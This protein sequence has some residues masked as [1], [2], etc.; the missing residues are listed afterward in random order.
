MTRIARAQA[1]E[2]LWA[3]WPLRVT[4]ALVSGDLTFDQ[5]GIAAFL[6]AQADYRK[7]TFIATLSTIADGLQWRGSDDKLRRDLAVLRENGW[8]DYT[9][10]ERQRKPYLIRLTGLL[11]TSHAEATAAATAAPAPPPVRQSTVG[12]RQSAKLRNAE[13]KRLR[14]APELSTCGSPQEEKRREETKDLTDDLTER[15]TEASYA[16]EPTIDK[17]TDDDRLLALF[18]ESRAE[19]AQREADERRRAFEGGT[20]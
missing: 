16:S 3:K 8:I 19:R 7:H 4:E 2:D 9:V 13:P 17:T 14:V 6:C 5:H 18:D 10:T 15:T 1:E 11:V 12:P 20:A